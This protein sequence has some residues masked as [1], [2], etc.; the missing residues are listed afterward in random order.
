MKRNLRVGIAVSTACLV[1]FGGGTVANAVA[2]ATA[3][4]PLTL[5]E[6]GANL[7][8]A[9]GEIVP[10]TW[11]TFEYDSAYQR[12]TRSNGNGVFTKVDTDYFAREYGISGNLLG[13]FNNYNVERVRTKATSSAAW[14]RQTD[15]TKTVV[16]TDLTEDLL[17]QSHVVD[18]RICEDRGVLRADPCKTTSLTFSH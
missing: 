15:V 11:Q 8:Q 12:D 17:G 13:Y 4:S 14:T 3:T 7:A 16:G 1:I 6:D 9:R 5:S 10:K 18:V 2:F